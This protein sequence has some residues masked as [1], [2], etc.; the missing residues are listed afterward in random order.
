MDTSTILKTFIKR[1]TLKTLIF[2]AICAAV[3]YFFAQQYYFQLVPLVFLY[4]YVVNIIVFSVLIKSHN[5]STAKFSRRFLVITMLKFL[6]SLIF[7]FLFMIF[8]REHMIP[9][10]V[11]FIILYFLSL[12]QVVRGFLGFINQ[13]K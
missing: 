1:L 12:S 13:K 2:A 10:L 11:I 8:A 6:G 7:A 9:F 3:F 5:L 4:F